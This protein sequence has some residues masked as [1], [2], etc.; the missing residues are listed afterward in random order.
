MC[1]IVCMVTGHC[2]STESFNDKEAL[3]MWS[4]N[5]NC[6]MFGMMWGIFSNKA[7]MS[8]VGNLRSE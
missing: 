8:S 7:T 4:A 2:I 1:A 3:Q 5:V 6:W